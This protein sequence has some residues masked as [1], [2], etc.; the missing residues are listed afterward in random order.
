LHKQTAWSSPHFL[1]KV[2]YFLSVIYLLENVEISLPNN[3]NLKF[4][5]HA[6]SH[7]NAEL[8][9]ESESHSI[10]TI[11]S[12]HSQPW[13]TSIQSQKIFDMLLS[14]HSTML[15]DLN[16]ILFCNGNCD[17]IWVHCRQ[18]KLPQ[19]SRNENMIQLADDLP[20]LWVFSFWNDK[21][22]YHLG[23]IARNFQPCGMMLWRCNSTPHSQGLLT[24]RTWS[25]LEVEK[26]SSEC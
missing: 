5:S 24:M 21:I 7:K 23:F 11:C 1:Q 19:I 9:R 20:S 25:M 22:F 12:Q 2:L 4:H 16:I 13:K 10:A 18:Y 17:V 15:C 3:P 8:S 14:T 6:S 26:N